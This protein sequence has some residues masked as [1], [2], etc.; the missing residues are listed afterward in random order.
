M[1]VRPIFNCLEEL[2][3]SSCRQ[4]SDAAITVICNA[5][6]GENNNHGNNDIDNDNTNYSTAAALSSLKTLLL[7]GDGVVMDITDA[8]LRMLAQVTM[9]NNNNNNNH[10][11]DDGDNSNN[12]NYDNIELKRGLETLD[13]SDCWRVT[14][15]GISS[16]T[17]NQNNPDNSETDN[18]SFVHSIKSINLSN[19]YEIGDEA[20]IQGNFSILLL[21]LL[22]S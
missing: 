20:I 19:C 17:A 7:S 14:D 2:N 4:L 8:A 1:L 18:D 11:A 3:L 9:F 21:S 12:N 16:L 10:Q 15:D 13:L 22:L 5:I 6:T